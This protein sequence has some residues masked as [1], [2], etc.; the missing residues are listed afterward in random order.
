MTTHDE[1]LEKLRERLVSLQ[2]A[3]RTTILAGR[4]EASVESMA[5]VAHET[6]AD[7]IYAVDLISERAILDWFAAEWPA[8]EPVE[9]VA[10][11]LEEHGA[12]TF[13]AGTPV[14]ETR[15]K[16][17]IDPI[18]GTRNFMYDK[19]SAWVLAAVAPQR[20]TA[21]TLR[22]LCVA[23]M[24][25]LPV[26]K[27]SWSDE[28]SALRGR[29]REGM[30]ALS[31]HV[32]TGRERPLLLRP[33]TATDFKHG[34]ASLSRFFPEGKALIARMEERLWDELYGLGST[35][36]P[37]IFDDQYICSGGQFYELMCGHDR[38]L[39]DL[40]PLVFPKLGY[41]L[42]LSCHP[43]DVCAALILEEAGCVIEAPDGS[44]LDPPLDTVTPVAWM[45]Y[46]NPVL[47][48]LAR[49]ILT[50]IFREEGML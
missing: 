32:E 14:E 3:I 35:A 7:T 31:H 45:G 25:E 8:D 21:N 9:L 26:R 6:A 4:Q 27:Q 47:A 50:R 30:R 2:R 39:G 40:R 20:G 28:V 46:A 23:A 44:P 17:I 16:C 13:P 49:P 48:D 10:E 15:W 24:T 19:R 41:G 43:Y 5:A 22:D 18:D 11:G 12:V 38:L 36:S 42:S 37:L 29:G 1:Q 33:S 34:F